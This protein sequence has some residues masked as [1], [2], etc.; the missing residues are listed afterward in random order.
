MTGVFLRRGMDMRE[1]GHVK[2]EAKVG[3]M[4][5]QSKGSLGPKKDSSLEPSEKAWPC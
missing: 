2:T 4:L 1:E 3:L 5:L